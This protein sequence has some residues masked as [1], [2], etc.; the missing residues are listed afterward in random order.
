M[1]SRPV[2]VAIVV[3]WIHGI[4]GHRISINLAQEL[5]G[6][7]AKVDFYIGRIFEPLVAPVRSGLGRATLHVGQTIPTGK[8]S[9]VRYARFQYSRLLD[10]EI[11][12]SIARDHAQTPFDV[13]FVVSNEGHWLAGY[14]RK[15]LRPR[16][17]LLAVNVR[18]MVEHPFW[19]G[20][21]RAWSLPRT[22]FSPLYPLAHQIEV[23]RLREFDVV[24][25]NSPWT[26]ELLDYFYGLRRSPTLMVVDRIFYD[27]PVATRP[28]EYVAVATAS[29]D[30]AGTALLREIH[31]QVPNLRTY[32][33]VAVPGI[34]HEGFLT[35]QKLVEFMAGAA[36]NLFLFDYE[37]LGLIPLESLAAGTPVVTVPKQ[38]PLSVLAGNP[39]VRFGLT[40]DQLVAGL[41][42]V[43][44]LSRDP[45]WRTSCRESVRGLDPKHAT[46]LWLEQLSARSALSASLARLRSPT[47]VPAP[48]A[49][50]RPGPAVNFRG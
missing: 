5:A 25:A 21:E 26:A 28:S 31:A 9:M 40:P 10:R 24:F 13:V 3:P 2:S 12:R 46:D 11:S 36:A 43:M 44:A 15:S 20:Y 38:G 14:L 32:G 18:E 22:L 17:P 7:G 47:A 37:A 30:P 48:A 16:V 4:R 34:P 1:S 6:R 27:A 33:K 23:Q 19:L 45:A 39:H 50:T 29:L 42:D 35:D 8:T 49:G 41:R